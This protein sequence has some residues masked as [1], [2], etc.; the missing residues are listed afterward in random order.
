MVYWEYNQLLYHSQDPEE[1]FV[2]VLM[3]LSNVHTDN[4]KFTSLLNLLKLLNSQ[5]NWASLWL[6]EQLR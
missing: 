1:T 6:N 4:F 3:I 2:E 5:L